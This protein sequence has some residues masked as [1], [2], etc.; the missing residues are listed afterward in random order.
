MDTDD[1]Q[2]GLADQL[3]TPRKPQ[4]RQM[5]NSYAQKLVAYAGLAAP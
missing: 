5:I 3:D 4:A 2:R 1:N